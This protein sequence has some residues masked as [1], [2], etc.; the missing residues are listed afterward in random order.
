MLIQSIVPDSAE[1]RSV[2]ELGSFHVDLYE[3]QQCLEGA[4]AARDVD[5]KLSQRL[6]TL[7]VIAY[8]RCF[9]SHVRPD[10]DTLIPV[11]N[12]HAKTHSTAKA[13]RNKYAAHSENDM[14][15]TFVT[16]YVE[17]RGE[18]V[19]ATKVRAITATASIPDSFVD[20]MAEL[21]EAYI[22]VHAQ[23]LIPLKQALLASLTG[24]AKTSMFSAPEEMQVTPLE[25]DDWTPLNRRRRYLTSRFIPIYMSRSS[26]GRRLPASA[27]LTLC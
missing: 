25:A 15:K 14:V 3:A 12:G 24:E 5:Q 26:D 1:A 23:S 18:G 4:A 16:V 17:D 8:D 10:L 7:A 6:A 27:N 13:L 20:A 9:G 21:V 2:S 19:E 11:P 22:E